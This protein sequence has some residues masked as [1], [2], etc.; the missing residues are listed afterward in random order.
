MARTERDTI[1]GHPFSSLPYSEGTGEYQW[2]A[3][4]RWERFAGGRFIWYDGKVWQPM[5]S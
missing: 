3:N 5:H 1:S 4:G 2:Y